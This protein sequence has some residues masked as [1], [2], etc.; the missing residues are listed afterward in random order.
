[1]HVAVFTDSRIA[2]DEDVRSH[3]ASR[4]DADTSLDDRVGFDVCGGVDFRRVVDDRARM[5]PAGPMR[6][7]RRKSVEDRVKGR[8]WSCHTQKHLR[9]HL[10]EARRH[11]D[12]VRLGRAQ[13][14]KVLGIL[15]ESN[16]S[17]LRLVERGGAE[18]AHRRIG[19]AGKFRPD[20]VGD[21]VQGKRLNGHGS[22]EV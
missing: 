9:Q 22:R 18:D 11:Q 3:D 16:L 20:G 6:C 19:A 7:H 14:T 17:R 2:S 13:R 15:V 21:F 5:N 4:S 1:M 8:G 12:D 10:I